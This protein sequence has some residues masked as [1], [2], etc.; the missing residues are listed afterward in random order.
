MLEPRD[1][2]ADVL[3]LKL[4]GVNLVTGRNDRVHPTAHVTEAIAQVREY[5]AYFEDRAHRED[6]K[7]RYGLKAYRPAVAILIGRDPGPGRDPFE[8]R[9]IWDELPPRVELMTYDELLQRVRRL[10]RF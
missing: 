9:R 4:P 10:G 7:N 1:G 5:R 3:D 6:V 2:F 8:L